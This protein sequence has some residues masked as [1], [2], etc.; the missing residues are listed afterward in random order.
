MFKNIPD[1]ELMPV[2]YIDDDKGQFVYGCDR[3]RSRKATGFLNRPY[4]EDVDN[5]FSRYAKDAIKYA[6]YYMWD[7]FV[8]KSSMINEQ[9][10]FSATSA[11]YD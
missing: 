11:A 5:R 10:T 6:P 2:A 1:K 8:P 4:I 7:V 9:R 3:A